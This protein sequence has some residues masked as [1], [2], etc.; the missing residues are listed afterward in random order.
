M[1][2]ERADD[3]TGPGRQLELLR[4]LEDLVRAQGRRQRAADAETRRLRAAI[5]QAATRLGAMLGGERAS[6][7]ALQAVV[8]D[9]R[10][11]VDADGP[12]DEP[13]A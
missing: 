1:T 3:P 2:E 9:L 10:A 11:A 8:D 13:A 5:E 4:E 6:R 7:A 12:P